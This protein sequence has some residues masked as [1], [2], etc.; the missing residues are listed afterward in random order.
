MGNALKAEYKPSPNNAK[1]CKKDCQSKAKCVAS[2]YNYDK[3]ACTLHTA[4]DESKVVDACAKCKIFRK[5][6]TEVKPTQPSPFNPRNGKWCYIPNASCNMPID[7]L[8]NQVII[9]KLECMERCLANPLCK[10]FHWRKWDNMPQCWI[11]PNNCYEESIVDNNGVK[12]ILEKTGHHMMSYID[13]NPAPSVQATLIP[14]DGDCSG[15]KTNYVNP[16]IAATF[17]P[18]TNPDDFFNTAL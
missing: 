9:P 18:S 4:Y 7:N 17:K 12:H 11:V 6:C 1:Q 15:Y 13:L 5:D 16:K 2:S 8:E 14:K 3:K 10:S